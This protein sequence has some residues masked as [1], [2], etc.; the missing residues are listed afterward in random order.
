MATSRWLQ[1]VDCPDCGGHGCRGQY[2]DGTERCHKCSARSGEAGASGPPEWALPGDYRSLGRR[3]IS[4]ETCRHWGYQVGTYRGRPCHIENHRDR[5]GRLVAQKIRSAGKKFSWVGNHDSV[6][7][8]G[9]WLWRDGGKKVVVTEG[10]IDALSMSEVQE[11][12]W[13]VVS[14]PDGAGSAKGAILQDLEWLEGFDQVV[15][16]FDM[17]DAGREAAIECAELL[18]PGK[19][20]IANLPLKDPNEML[21]AGRRRELLDAM[22]GAK[23]YRPDGILSFGEAYERFLEAE[24]RPAITY[25]FPELQERTHGFRKGQVAVV[26]AGTSVGKTTFTTELGYHWVRSGQKVGHIA[27]EEDYEDVV[28]NYMTCALNQVVRLQEDP[29]EVLRTP[30]AV[31]ALRRLDDQVV[32]YD[33]LG[34]A[35]P[36]GIVSRLRY[37]AVGMRCDVIILDHLSI[38][39][40]GAD[41]NDERKLI[42]NL[43][44]KIVN[45]A[46]GTGCRIMVIC[47]LRKGKGKDGESHEEGGRVTL[48]DGRGSGGIKQLAYDVIALERN[49]QA[50]SDDVRNTTRLRVLKTR[51]GRSTGPAG[52]I[53]Y[54]TDTGRLVPVGLEEGEMGGLVDE[55]PPET[56]EI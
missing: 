2:E 35:D 37:L 53:R 11:N 33:D 31:D 51:H 34:A 4:E 24:P 28:Q 27:L 49:L 32:L 16:M 30:E 5:Q 10:A 6:G 23:A 19:A 46:K 55:S 44:T 1:N 39:V 54:D 43:L 47:H 29:R 8:Y 36:K 25:P 50:V 48:D 18:P 7:L 52:K 13:P 12:R 42:D 38:I 3:R 26:L 56:E 9:A 41:S 45:V 14:V 15:L 21:Q 20:F 22:W 40:S 17:D